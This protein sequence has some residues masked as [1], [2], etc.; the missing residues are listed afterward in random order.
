MLGSACKRS[1]IPI[2]VAA[3]LGT[4]FFA[5]AQKPVPATHLAQADFLPAG[6]FLFAPDEIHPTYMDAFDA[7]PVVESPNGKLAVTVTGPK[8]SLGAWVT[9]NPST[10]PDGPIQLWP[11]EASVDALW[12]PDSRALALTDN[13]YANTS[14]VLLVG[15]E[16]HMGESDSELGVPTTD[17]TPIIRKAFEQQAKKYYAG[18]GYD[19]LL[20]Y[21]KALRWLGYGRILTGVSARTEGPAS[22]PNRGIKDWAQGYLVDV[23]YALDVPDK[24][25]VGELNENQLL[26]RYGIKVAK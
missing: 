5:A 26:S 3:F 10:F 19:T 21:A 15:T 4:A 6:P 23:P 7:R 17:L 20:F 2:L 11:F 25:V 12:R 13:R 16:F 22:L 18:Q 1:R 9:L 24:K 8:R 14:Y